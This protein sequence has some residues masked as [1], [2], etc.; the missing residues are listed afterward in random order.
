MAKIISVCELT[1][2]NKGIIVLCH[3][4]FDLLH[5]GHIKYFQKAKEFGDTLIVTITSDKYVNKGSGRPIFNEQ[6]RA[7]AIASL[8][9]VDYVAINYQS[10]AVNVIK[11]LK[12]KFFVKGREYEDSLILD[13]EI[14]AADECGCQIRFTDEITFS[15]S[16]I[17]NK[18]TLDKQAIDYLSIFRGK[19]DLSYIKEQIDNINTLSVLV[20]G[21]IIVDEYNYGFYI[22]K[23]RRE[24]IMEFSTYRK[25]K[26]LGG[27]AAVANHLVN[28]TDNVDIFS[29]INYDQHYDFI[30]SELNSI[31]DRK[32]IFNNK[33]TFVKRRFIEDRI[34]YR[35]L[36]KSSEIDDS[37]LSL[38]E[39][40]H[41][42]NALYNIIE[43]YDLVIVVDYGHGFIGKKFA[44]IIYR[45]NN[46]Y[47]AV[48]TQINTENRGFNLVSKYNN[49]D[50]VCINENEL[51]TLCRDKYS[52]LNEH[53]ISK[54]HDYIT[55][56]DVIITCGYSGSVIMDKYNDYY[57][58]PVFS[59]KVVDAMGAGD[60]L[61]SITA[62][63]V[64]LDTTM[65]LVGFIG[66]VAAAEHVKYPG[67][68]YILDKIEL[69]KKIEGLLK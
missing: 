63:L 18:L 61:F 66:N 54:I 25:E 59:T 39:V 7:E 23:G 56:E 26:F 4:V 30:N 34:D 42:C 36:F 57:E 22:G 16:N 67:N 58:V 24:S 47:I 52:V 44:E 15:S 68:S 1:N 29:L 35:S 31:V 45:A 37:L 9:C 38:E 69:I 20:I 21:E 50:Y 13:P 8:E 65:D 14:K 28:F 43:S 33:S 62:P 32:W 53:L 55:V 40:N 3:G 60:A 6:L 51:R 48:N 11:V 49:V 27:A 12:P 64:A 19:Y 46:P 5:I 2:I 10:T 41:V 17:I